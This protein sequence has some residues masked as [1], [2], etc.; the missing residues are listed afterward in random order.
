MLLDLCNQLPSSLKIEINKTK[1]IEKDDIN[2]IK[3]NLSFND[4]NYKLF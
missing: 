2:A 1:N 4:N 3:A